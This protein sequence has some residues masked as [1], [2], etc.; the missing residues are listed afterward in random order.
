[1][2]GGRVGMLI[3]GQ[4]KALHLLVEGTTTAQEPESRN[5]FSFGSHRATRGACASGKWMASDKTCACPRS[6]VAKVQW[7]GSSSRTQK[8]ALGPHGRSRSKLI[9]SKAM[10]SPLPTALLYASLS[11]Q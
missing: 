6:K 4:R 3:P 7:Q 9:R 5:R 10:P 2:D 8:V 11:V 1:M